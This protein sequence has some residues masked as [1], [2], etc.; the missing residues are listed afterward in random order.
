[1][2][3]ICITLVLAVFLFIAAPILVNWASGYLDIR[4]MYDVQIYSGYND[5]YEEENLPHDTYDL[6]TDFL[7]EHKLEA[8]YDC[9]FHLYLPNK[10][11]FHSRSKY[12]FPDAAV[13]LSDYNAIREML[14]YTPV[15]LAENAFTTQWKSIAETEEIDRFLESHTRVATDA[16]TLTLSKQSFYEDSIGETAYNSYTNVLYVFPDK[17]CER[18]LP[19]MQNRYI[20]TKDTISYENARQ[21]EKIFTAKYPEETDKET[22]YGI[23]LSTLQINSTKASNFILQAAMLYGAVVLMVIC[24]TILSLQ[25]LLDADQY[26]YRFSVLRKLGVEEPRIQKLVLKQLGVW[27][28]LPVLV[29]VIVA[30]VV[31]AYFVQ[32]ISAEISAY[33]GVTALLLQAGTTVSIL[34]GL[35]LCYFISTWILFSRS[36]HS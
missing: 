2:T 32:S 8:A 24:L 31:I 21:L 9:T 18:L 25:Q 16:G 5:V 1:M 10:D 14:G 28:G 34:A 15:S 36:I 17:V 22:S 29:A 20:T 11:D 3:L 27:F 7:A 26:K 13:S 30:A 19:V 35:F 23:R 4:S 6:V 33:I 12:D